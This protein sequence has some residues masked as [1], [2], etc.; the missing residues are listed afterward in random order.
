M[1]YNVT[2]RYDLNNEIQIPVS[3]YHVQKFMAFS[4]LASVTKVYTENF[5]VMKY[6]SV[7]CTQF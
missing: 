5:V 6:Y 4:T 1:G 2:L 3:W 7:S